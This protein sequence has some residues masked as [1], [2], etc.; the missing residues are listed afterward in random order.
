MKLVLAVGLG[1]FFGGAA[2]YLLSRF[3]QWQ[4]S[5]AFPWGTLVVNIM[6]CFL[7]GI[8]YAL[9]DR[10]HLTD[11]WRLVLATGVIGG[12]T[13]FS[14]FSYESLDLIRGGQYVYAGT[15]IAAS[16]IAGLAATVLGIVLIK[17]L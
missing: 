4:T 10:G 8:V 3:I 7:I 13:T 5:S 16:V 12:F 17:A 6:G 1:S 2:R 11:E 9:A 15:Y 14:A